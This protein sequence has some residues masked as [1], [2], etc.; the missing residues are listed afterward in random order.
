[1]HSIPCL[2]NLYSEAIMRK[3]SLDEAPGWIKTGGLKINN[4]RYADDAT[5]IA[6]TKVDLVYLLSKVKEI[7]EQFALFQ[8]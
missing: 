6:T 1:M 3:V 7:S 5:L 2:F 8:S 4:L